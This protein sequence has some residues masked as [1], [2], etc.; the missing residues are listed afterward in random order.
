MITT[1]NDVKMTARPV[2]HPWTESTASPRSYYR[3][4]AT[5]E[6]MLSML[7]DYA[8]GHSCP[9]LGVTV[10]LQNSEKSSASFSAED[11]QSWIARTFIY[12]R[13]VHPMVACQIKDA[14]QM[15]YKVEEAADVREWAAR[16]VQTIEYSS[17]WPELLTKLSRQAVLPPEDGD[18]AFLYLVLRPPQSSKSWISQFDLLLHEHHGLVDGA[19]IRSIMNEVLVGLTKLSPTTSYSWGEKLRG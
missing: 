16:T 10:S 7:N 6:F 8:L 15:V 3:T 18:C 13:W 11:L 5:Q 9:Y 2:F 1:Y 19:G 14:K 4:L 12:T 17:G